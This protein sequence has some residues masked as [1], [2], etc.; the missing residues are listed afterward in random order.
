M[1]V[2]SP[3]FRAA[4]LL[5]LTLFTVFFE[6]GE[7]NITT[8]NEGQRA[9]PPA[10]MLE[11]GDWIVP[12][13]NDQ[14][15][16]AKPPLLYWATAG[17]YWV[18][19]VI[20]EWT[21][22]LVTATCAVL[23]IQVMFW[24]ARRRAGDDVAFF[25]AL[26]MASAP[27][28]LE[29]ARWANLD[30]P[31]L[32]TTFVAVYLLYASW[33]KSGWASWR[34][35]LIAGLFLGAATMLKG[36]VPYLF[37]AGAYVAFIVT[38]NVLTEDTSTYAFRWAA[39]GIV[40]ALVLYPFPIPFPVALA[41]V[42]LAWIYLCVRTGWEHN[43]RALP[44]T[45]VACL[46]GVASAAPWALSMIVQV[47][48]ELPGYLGGYFHSEVTQRTYEATEI[49]SGSPLFFILALPVMFAPWGFLLPL[50]LS[51]R[52]WKDSDEFYR[53][54]L[55]MSW[56]SITLF[57]LIAG[58]EYEY[59]LPCTPFLLYALGYFLEAYANDV[60]DAGKRN[61][62]FRWS[63]GFRWFLVVAAVGLV[64][65]AIVEEA[66][67]AG[68]AEAVVIGLLVWAILLVRRHMSP[69]GHLI[70]VGMAAALI[71]SGVLVVRSYRYQEERSP[72]AMAEVC[73]EVMAAGYEIEATKI[74]AAFDFYSDAPIPVNLT[75]PKVRA[76]LEG[77]TPY[78][79]LTRTDFM[80]GFGGAKYVVQGPIKNQR[81][82]LLGN[83]ELP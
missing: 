60:I 49:N 10:A 75:A 53:F 78:F 43:M 18:T 26:A 14:P 7:M 3:A 65:Y 12:R 63:Q 45:L 68:I 82:V 83:T 28:F 5:V 23:L 39:G 77:D 24:L 25:A 16:V 34:T 74:F 51:Y 15:Y 42:S 47:Q 37:V 50:Q 30:I 55:A 1:D 19:G 31:L 2:S 67:G 76:K 40:L 6:L 79:Y 59:I 57:S 72:K 33:N 35:A 80:D 17:V 21:A 56:F 69:Q 54:A 4:L 9:A 36:P 48:K 11:N 41:V 66:P 29:R 73:N 64:V 71:V 46:I 32:L 61:W 20:S 44:Q 8:E 70:R 58:K 52:T 38:R 81:L 22:R 62:I 27:Y 13:L